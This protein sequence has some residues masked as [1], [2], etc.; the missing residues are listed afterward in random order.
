[1]TSNT[2][3]IILQKH[4]FA[5]KTRIGLNRRLPGYTPRPSHSAAGKSTKCR[6][7]CQ[8]NALMPWVGSAPWPY[9]RAT[10]FVESV[11]PNL[12]LAD[13]T[14][15]IEAN[16]RRA[17]RRRH[18]QRRHHRATDPGRT[19]GQ[20]HHHYPR[21]GRHQRHRLGRCG[22]SATGPTGGGAL[23]GCRR[24]TGDSPIRC[25]ST[26]KARRARC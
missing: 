7:Q 16:V 6:R 17:L 1:M 14:A 23:A 12:R 22:V 26:S 10:L 8:R 11:M 13:L 21:R 2:R 3:R 20:S 18:R 15:E 19:P 24:R 25:C 9:N 5:Q 4:A